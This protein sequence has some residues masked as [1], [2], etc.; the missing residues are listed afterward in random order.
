MVEFFF[1]F[2]LPLAFK[3]NVE[4]ESTAAA[5]AAGEEGEPVASVPPD[6]DR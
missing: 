6:P 2:K 1:L 3:V 4:D 5:A